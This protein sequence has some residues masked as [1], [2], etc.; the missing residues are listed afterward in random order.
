[1][2]DP[3]GIRPDINRIIE[4]AI[5]RGGSVIACWIVAFDWATVR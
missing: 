5:T 2:A 4:E 1:M 3:P